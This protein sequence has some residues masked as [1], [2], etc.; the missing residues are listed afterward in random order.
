[1]WL[2]H[3]MGHQIQLYHTLEREIETV[4]ICLSDSI[5]F[6]KL[7]RPSGTAPF[8]EAFGFQVVLSR[9]ELQLSAKTAYAPVGE[10]RL[11]RPILR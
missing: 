10:T 8:V 2:C 4:Y 11:T 5:H 3:G 6:K 9:V 1:M 7:W